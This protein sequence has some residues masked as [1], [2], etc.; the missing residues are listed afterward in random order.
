MNVDIEFDQKSAINKF[1]VSYKEPETKAT[2]PQTTLSVIRTNIQTNKIVNEP[3]VRELT[4]G[5]VSFS[6]SLSKYVNYTA[7]STSAQGIK[8]V[9]RSGNFSIEAIELYLHR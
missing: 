6:K 2:I 7:V 3:F 8:F 1:N 4:F 5:Q 9:G